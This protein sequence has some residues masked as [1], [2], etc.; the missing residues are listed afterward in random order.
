MMKMVGGIATD[1]G[2]PSGTKDALLGPDAGNSR[3]HVWMSGWTDL[4]TRTLS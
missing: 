3:R 4:G 2:E 1:G